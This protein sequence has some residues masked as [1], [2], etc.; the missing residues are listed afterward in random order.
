LL[1]VYAGNPTSN[2]LHRKSYMHGILCV[3]CVLCGNTLPFAMEAGAA[4]V[5]VPLEGERVRAKLVSVDSGGMVEFHEVSLPAEAGSPEGELRAISFEEFVRWGNPA[6]LRPQIVVVL[7]DGGRLVTAAAWAGGAAVRLEDESVVVLSDVFGEVSIPRPSVSGIVFAQRNHPRQREQL[8]Q[9]VRTAE[10]STSAATSAD[11]ILLSN[12]DRVAGS[13]TELAGGSLVLQVGAERVKLP[14]SR[15]EAVAFGGS[16]RLPA[17]SRQSKIAVGMH[18][19]SLLYTERIVANEKELGFALAGGIKLGGGT[20]EDLAFMQSLGGPFVYLSDLEPADYRHVPYLAIAWPY[21]RDRNVLG[22]PLSVGGRRYLKGIGMHSASRLTY[23]LDG[24][25]R[26]FD[27]VVALDD[28]AEEQGS[29]TFGVYVLR[30]GAWKEAYTSGIVRGGE[31]P[32][33][34]SVNVHGAEGLTLTVDFAD[35]GDELDRAVWLDAR[36]VKE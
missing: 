9:V 6:E 25:Y 5:L 20:V 8:E 21:R 1:N 15:V 16:R 29:V 17:A 23:R 18:D 3:L 4:A 27:A 13:V 7:A 33:P 22:E 2:I 12:N 11:S 19:G 26:R 36:L 28:S 30:D 34:V 32:R 24:R 10:I 35:R 31:A 14:L